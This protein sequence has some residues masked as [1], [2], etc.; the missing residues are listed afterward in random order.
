MRG[1][2]YDIWTFPLMFEIERG[3]NLESLLRNGEVWQI[4][5]KIASTCTTDCSVQTKPHHSYREVFRCC[6]MTTIVLHHQAYLSI[7]HCCL[8]PC[9]RHWWFRCR[10]L[11]DLCSCAYLVGD[12]TLCVSFDR[13]VQFGKFTNDSHCSHSLMT[14]RLIMAAFQD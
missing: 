8:V 10:I 13:H 2:G 14:P 1:W 4:G 3:S 5:S 12:A 9:S 6:S 7:V 11:D